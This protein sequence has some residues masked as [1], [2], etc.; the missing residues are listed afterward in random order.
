MQAGTLRLR[1][2]LEELRRKAEE[3]ERSDEKPGVGNMKRETGK[4]NSPT[5]DNSS[6][7][8]SLHISSPGLE[9]DLRG[10]R[11]EDA[12]DMLDRYLE[13][14]YMAGLP[15]VRIIHGKGNRQVTPGST[16]GA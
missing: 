13:K 9:L 7:R 6:S 3:T 2:R 15:F 4:R 1:V 16:Y 10:Q 14:A 11:A 12:L 8:H 5:A